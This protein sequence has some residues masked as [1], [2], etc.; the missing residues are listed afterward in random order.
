VLAALD[1]KI[2]A[3]RRLAG[4]LEEI[5]ATLF[6]AHLVDFVGLDEL[7]ESELGGIPRGWSAQPVASLARYVN[8]RAFTKYG[9][10]RGRMVIRIA[11]LR[12]GPG[13]STVYTDHE[14]QDDHVAR[15]GDI[16]FAWSGALDVYRWHR[17][18][19][20][21][22][23]HIFKV[24]PSGVPDWFVYLSLKHVMPRFQAIAADKATTMG[25]IKRSH[26]AE[27]AV[28][29]PPPEDFAR[30][31][32]VFMPVFDRSL[33]AQVENE[34][35]MALRDAFLPKLISGQTR[36]PD[37]YDPDEVLGPAIE[38]VAA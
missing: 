27:L 20:L 5:A 1:D 18:D 17:E 8:G 30:W 2:D 25:H 10:G 28:A 16:L 13:G 6:R 12:S 38:A 37:T 29:V 3:N 22:N 4:T 24:M 7:E 31:D 9:N 14:A 11:D 32:S 21:I 33:E 15:S 36:V 23:Q 34:T 19:A 35:L 26:L